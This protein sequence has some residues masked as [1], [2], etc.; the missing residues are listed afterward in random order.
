MNF[1]LTSVGGFDILLFYSEREQRANLALRPESRFQRRTFGWV[2]K[3]GLGG[4]RCRRERGLTQH[5]LGVG[6]FGGIQ[7]IHAQ[8]LLLARTTLEIQGL[9]LVQLAPNPG[10]HAM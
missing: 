5:V 3:R 8:L 7:Q 4:L 1:E 6:R 10:K 9:R 2:C